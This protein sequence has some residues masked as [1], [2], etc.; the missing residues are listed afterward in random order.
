MGKHREDSTIS[1]EFFNQ[2]G[3]EMLKAEK[4]KEENIP[5]AITRLQLPAQVAENQKDPQEI[6]RFWKHLRRFF[7]SGNLQLLSEYTLEGPPLPA[8]IDMV[9]HGHNPEYP[10]WI[11]QTMEGKLSGCHSLIQILQ[12]T[13]S[14]LFDDAENIMKGNIRRLFSIIVKKIGL[15]ECTYDGP[16]ILE[17]SLEDLKLQLRLNREEKI[18]FE[19]DCQ[20]FKQ[21][22]PQDGVL[23]PFSNIGPFAVLGQILYIEN[24]TKRD[25]FEREINPVISKLKDILEVENRKSPQTNTPEK[26]KE[27]LD[28]AAPFVQF[29]KLSALMQTG[30]E[31]MMPP[32]RLE[33]LRRT[34]EVLKNASDVLF[35]KDAYLIAANNWLEEVPLDIKP[36]FKNVIWKTCESHQIFKTAG[37]IFDQQIKPQVAVFSAWNL[38]KLE[39]ANQYDPQIHEAYFADYNWKSLT[40]TEI[41]LCM[42][43]IILADTQDTL[44]AEMHHFSQLLTSNR[45]IKFLIFKDPLKEPDQLDFK[46]ELGPF[47]FVHRNTYFHQST[48]I[49]V[50]EIYHHLIT[51]IRLPIPS[52]GH[53]L[54]PYSTDKTTSYHISL[55]ALEGRAF[56]TYTYNPESGPEW[57]KRFSIS[58]NPSPELRWPVK[59][60]EVQNKSGDIQMLDQPLTYAHY[61]LSHPQNRHLFRIVPPG[62]WTDNLIPLSSYL[63]LD[64]KE[65]ISLIPYIWMIDKNRFLQKVVLAAP[66]VRMSRERL[67]FWRSLQEYAG[68]HNYHVEEAI[69]ALKVELEDKYSK[70]QK[71]LE[72]RHTKELSEIKAKATQEAM[73][74]LA[75][76]LLDLGSGT[77]PLKNSQPTQLI[78][79]EKAETSEVALK[80]ELKH[81]DKPKEVVSDYGAAYIDTPLCTSCNECIDIN[82]EIF[83][84][85]GN[86]QA[87]IKNKNGRFSDIVKAAEK[88]PARIIHPGTPVNMQ[89]KNIEKWIKRAK[90]F[91]E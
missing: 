10:I 19:H 37:E 26:L 58:N 38:A 57:G 69:Q 71:E 76:Y 41:S 42:P 21:H 65:T 52:V 60:V 16:T 85:D 91:N 68:V 25:Q 30:G 55:T 51:G 80:H 47:T 75:N 44:G 72:N 23:L 7:A 14:N 6:K 90:P 66:V 15:A 33:R 49:H 28:F 45:P 53:I 50:Q 74:Q 18:Q 4:G 9:Y 29:D 86:K 48:N 64:R 17:E 88:C 3:I 46:Q 83:A 89:E 54:N 39:I 56:P 61:M 1:Q 20:R 62:Y 67:D 24:K 73:A 12:E 43:M 81:E 2:E 34:L 11:S 27:H 8:N 32:E 78:Q 77:I 31:T 70:K 63:D 13:A 40:E 5:A 87:Y 79:H 59:S 82:R 84:Y 35:G 36:A 22:L